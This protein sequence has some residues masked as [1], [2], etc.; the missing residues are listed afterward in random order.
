MRVLVD[1]NILFSAILFPESN[2][3]KGYKSKQIRD[4]TDQPIVNAAIENNVD[5]ILTGDKDF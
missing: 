3:A 2:P 1:T 5:I 4:V